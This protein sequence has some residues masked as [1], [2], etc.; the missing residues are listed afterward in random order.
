MN[1][2][3]RNKF[4]IALTVVSFVTAILTKDGNYQMPILIMLT[5][6]YWKD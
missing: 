2:Q 6:L 1:F 3:S 5:A 4:S